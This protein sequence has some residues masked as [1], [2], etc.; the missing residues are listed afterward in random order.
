METE[1]KIPESGQSH[2]IETA[3]TVV[4][5]PWWKRLRYGRLAIALGLIAGIV[6]GFIALLDWIIIRPVEMFEL[7]PNNA[8]FYWVMNDIQAIEK[9]LSITPYNS[10]L[11]LF[12]PIATYRRQF[13]LLDSVLLSD[14][15][16]KKFGPV[17]TCF[18]P[19]GPEAYDFLH[20]I[21]SGRVSASDPKKWLKASMLESGRISNRNFKGF[22]VVEYSADGDSMIWAF[23]YCKGFFVISSTPALVDNF[24]THYLDG[25]VLQKDKSFRRVAVNVFKKPL[26]FF[27]HYSSMPDLGSIGSSEE[28]NSLLKQFASGPDWTGGSINFEPGGI[29]MDGVSSFKDVSQS[30]SGRL[31]RSFGKPMD[32]ASM[33]PAN[34]SIMEFSG[35][36]QP[37]DYFSE[38]PTNPQTHKDAFDWV[39]GEWAFFR[40]EGMEKNRDLSNVLLVKA[41]DPQKAL[42]LLKPYTLVNTGDSLRTS[43]GNFELKRLKMGKEIN[44][45]FGN[46][47]FTLHD[48]YFFYINS[49]FFFCNDANSAGMIL[50]SYQQGKV[51]ARDEQFVHF[52]KNTS[53]L[54]NSITYFNP[55]NSV[56]LIGSWLQ[57]GTEAFDAVAVS[58]FS[59]I[60]ITMTNDGG[61]AHTVIRIIYNLQGSNSGNTLWQLRLDTTVHQ[62][63]FVL[64]SPYDHSHFVVVQDDGGYVY[65]V[66]ASGEI[67]W[68]KWADSKLMGSPDVVDYY[69]N[70]DLQFTFNTGNFI[71]MI[72]RNGQYV[73]DYPIKLS[74]PASGG[75]TLFGSGSPHDRKILVPCVNGNIYGY[76]LSGKPLTGFNPLS[77]V[78]IL[79]KPLLVWTANGKQ[80]ILLEYESGK[81]L[82]FDER[83]QAG[84]KLSYDSISPQQPITALLSQGKTRFLNFGTGRL[85]TM[86]AEG[87]ARIEKLN[88]VNSESVYGA[89]LSSSQIIHVF[90]HDQQLLIMNDEMKILHE[91]KLPEAMNA[92]IRLAE[93]NGKVFIACMNKAMDKIYIYDGEAKLIK[94]CPLS[95]S[96]GISFSSLFNNGFMNVATVIKEGYLVTYRI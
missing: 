38:I 88:D 34:I 36:D 77:L 25:Q 67:I 90:L 95:G 87:V 33:I 50:Q 54:Y 83:A 41:S 80:N 32:I 5:K 15:D 12:G 3:I 21:Y 66:T 39:T 96:I 59:P 69:N 49:Y 30:R 44:D 28:G 47:Y 14:A 27:I 61:Y 6:Y 84:I 81:I 40:V 9:Q 86:D 78:G 37:D 19:Q 4:K 76:E 7:A 48:P 63:P 17:L 75:L 11:K 10:D 72:D 23:L 82:S 71:Y 92:K 62:E 73:E 13:A 55:A 89:V 60:S 65:L 42:N 20:I 31:L 58:H 46:T 18:Y 91:A 16:K 68:K 2:E 74:S 22:D 8:P 93:L 85:F 53:Q 24:I 56:S 1:E 45:L 94:G 29:V 51:L 26:N 79:K 52:L 64:E 43:K 35:T 57:G 70:E